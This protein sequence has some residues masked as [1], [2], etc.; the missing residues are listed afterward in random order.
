MIDLKDIPNYDIDIVQVASLDKPPKDIM[1]VKLKLNNFLRENAKYFS[2]ETLARFLSTDTRTILKFLHK[3]SLATLG[4][5]KANTILIV[6]PIDKFEGDYI[7]FQT[8]KI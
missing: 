7:K 4:K 6:R 1:D 5:S 8:G 2:I 3:T